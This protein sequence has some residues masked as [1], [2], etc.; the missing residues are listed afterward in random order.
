MGI[1]RILTYHSSKI[2]GIREKKFKI[3]NIFRRM[4]ENV[5]D[6]LLKKKLLR[7]VSVKIL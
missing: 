2:H 1:K 6:N 5:K 7:N 4:N 3:E